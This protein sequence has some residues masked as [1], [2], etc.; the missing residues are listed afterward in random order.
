[1]PID[2]FYLLIFLWGAGGGITMSM[3]R[4]IVQESAPPSHRARV[5]SVYSLGMMGGMPMGSLAMGYVI[6]V[7]GPLNAAWVPVIGMAVVV[8]WVS[9]KTN[10]WSLIPHPVAA[11]V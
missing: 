10:L 2:V 9:W 7:F 6:G 3:S 4:S 5:M 1:V 11:Q 8:A